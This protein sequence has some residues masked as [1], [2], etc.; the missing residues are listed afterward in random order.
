MMMNNIAKKIH[1]TIRTLPIDRA[2]TNG[3]DVNDFVI[4]MN[5]FERG[6][7]YAEICN[8]LGD[9]SR[10]WAENAVKNCLMTARTFYLNAVA[11]YRVGQY[12]II[13]DTDQSHI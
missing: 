8:R 12:T 11:A 10:D 4:L 1:A 13:Q 9:S 5:E 3:L 7:D 2:I 6:G